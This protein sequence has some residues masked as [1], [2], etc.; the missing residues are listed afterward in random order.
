MATIWIQKKPKRGK[1]F[2][3]FINDFK[4]K[5]EN[6]LKREFC[7]IGIFIVALNFTETKNSIKEQEYICSKLLTELINRKEFLASLHFEEAKEANNYFSRGLSKYIKFNKH[8]LRKKTTFMLR[9]N[10]ILETETEDYALDNF[11]NGS[12]K[13]FNS[14]ESPINKMR[15]VIKDLYMDYKY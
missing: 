6:F 7:I 2:N 10:K 8:S 4:L 5:K 1:L 14:N 12:E 15:I 13:L 9:A 11:L 3:K